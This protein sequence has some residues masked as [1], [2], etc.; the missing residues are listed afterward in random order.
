MELNTIKDTF[1]RVA[2]KQKLSSSKAQEVIDQ[3]SREIE[4][5]LVRIRSLQNLDQKSILTELKTKLKEIAPL[6]QLEGLQKELNAILS[7]YPKLLEKSFNP[8]ISKAYRNVDFDIHTVNQIIASHFYRQGLFDLGDCFI[9][10]A[11]EPE[12]A[13][14]KTP[15]LELYQILA[16]MRERNLELALN[17]AAT[18]RDKLKQTGSDV[19]LKL[20]RLQFVEIL[21]K[22]N[23]DEAL[24]Y[25]RTFLAPFAS[26]HLNEIQKLMACLLWAGRLDSSPYSELLSPTHWDTLT[27]ELTRQFCYLL[28]QSH[29]SPLS[30]TIAAGVQGL[31]T[32][33]KLMS[34]MMGKMQEWQTMKQ[35]PV[36]VDLDREF[37][38][39]SIFVC[40]VSREQA[41]EENPPMLMSCGHVL[42]KQS[43]MKMSKS[44]TR[45]FKCPYCP[46]EVDATHCRQLHF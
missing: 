38:F 36:P 13:G 23:R 21:Q 26:T 27:D 41:S 3:I 11:G 14:M 44:S 42:C 31:P 37:Q 17:W 32:L 43:I 28:G 33:L 20:H 46:M 16:A 9:N 1:D 29:E 22:G 18:N 30:V 10:E 15:F 12:A 6:G 24:K 4:Q 45:P 39:H 19:E 25:A 34:V 5:A 35:L 40:P 2:K 7:K 8:D